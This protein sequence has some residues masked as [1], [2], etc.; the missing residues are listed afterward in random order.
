MSECR[1]PTSDA[2]PTRDRR[3]DQPLDGGTPLRVA[4]GRQLRILIV[5]GIPVGVIVAGVGSR[6][7]ML[8][9][10]VSSPDHVIGIESD[11]G[12][13][14]GQFSLSGTYNLLMFGATVGILGAAA[15]Q[16]VA[17]WLIGPTWVRRLTVGL[18]AGVVVGSMVVHSDG[19][20]FNVLRPTWLAIGLFVLLPALFGVA[21]G[22]VVDR[23]S[24]P[25]SRS[26]GGRRS[27]ILPVVLVAAFPLTLAVVVVSGVVYAVWVLLADRARVRNLANTRVAGYAMRSAWLGVAVLGLIALARDVQALA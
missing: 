13:T 15:Y 24:G 7:A 22:P 16:C 3:A 4:V 2:E 1:R 26:D 18:A 14:I 11:D 21:I 10:R 9:L 6:L 25:T 19:V 8:A 23:V 12:F 5:A 27:W 17:P 20:D